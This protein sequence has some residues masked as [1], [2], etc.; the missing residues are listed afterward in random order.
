M[1]DNDDEETIIG[2]AQIASQILEGAREAVNEHTDSAE[3]DTGAAHISRGASGEGQVRPQLFVPQVSPSEVR[4]D[5]LDRDCRRNARALQ[6][7]DSASAATS[8]KD[9][10]VGLVIDGGSRPLGQSP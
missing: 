4:R 7:I 2:N 3:R 10:N 1:R 9:P 6:T 5:E 8:T